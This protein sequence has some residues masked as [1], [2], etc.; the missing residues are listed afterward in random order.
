MTRMK[1]WAM[2]AV[3]AALLVCVS[4]GATVAYLTSNSE[5]INTFTVGNVAITMTETKVNEKGEAVENAARVSANKYKLLPGHTYIKD[6]TVYVAEGSEDCWVFVKVENGIADIEAADGNIASQLAAND[7][8]AVAGA[9]GVYGR[10]QAATAGNELAVFETFTIDGE[11][12]NSAKLTDYA[13]AEVKV[14]AYAI[15][16]DGFASAADAWAALKVN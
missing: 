10:S 14:T 13:N 12:V 9:T 11:N 8:T 6:P 2:I 7:W 3:C 15:Q 16:A 1:K 5:V 4:I